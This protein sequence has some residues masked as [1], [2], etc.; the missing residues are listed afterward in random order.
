MRYLRSLYTGISRAEQGALVIANDAKT[1]QNINEVRSHATRDLQVLN[2]SP[3]EIRQ[4]AQRRKEQLE[5]LLP[6]YAD[7]TLKI[8]PPAIHY[9]DDV[10]VPEATPPKLPPALPPTPRVP[11]RTDKGWTDK[12]TLVHIMERLGLEGVKVK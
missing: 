6:N 7:E 2:I 5:T 10:E 4:N 11:R 3:E 8:E 12:M 1:G 9:N